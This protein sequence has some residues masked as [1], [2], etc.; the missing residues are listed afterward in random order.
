MYENVKTVDSGT[1]SCT[2]S[3]FLRGALTAAIF[4]F[5]VFALFALILSYT[6]LSEDAIPYIAFITQV[7]ASVIS[8]FV[9]ARRAGA[10]GIL[11]GGMSALLYM[12]IIWLIASLSSD[13]F[14]MGT[15]VIIMFLISL[16]FGALGGIMGV[17]LKATN[18]N[19]K[20]R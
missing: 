17:N 10:R 2:V 15:H 4:T 7:A 5:L 3:G 13:G 19:K 16:L 11:T 14:Y 9:P 1:F 18:N 12:L 8:G 6:P 20:K